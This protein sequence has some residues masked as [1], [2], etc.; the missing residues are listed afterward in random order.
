MVHRISNRQRDV[1]GAAV[2]TDFGIAKAVSGQP[3][4][5]PT[6]LT[7]RDRHRGLH[8]AGTGDGD[9]AWTIGDIYSLG[10][11]HTRS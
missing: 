10:A 6:S 7:G 2:V 11:W 1:G 4:T 5:T 3:G 8:G 9:P